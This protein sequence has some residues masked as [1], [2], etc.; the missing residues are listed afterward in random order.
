[1][2]PQLCQMVGG[3]TLAFDLVS[4]CVC[5]RMQ[6][7]VRERGGPKMK[8]KRVLQSSSVFTCCTAGNFRG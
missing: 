7:C 1:M 4:E 2:R 8:I 6:V 3:K 5:V